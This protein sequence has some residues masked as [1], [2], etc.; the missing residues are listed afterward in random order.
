MIINF[1]VTAFRK[2]IDVK[3]KYVLCQAIVVPEIVAT[4]SQHVVDKKIRRRFHIR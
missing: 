3:Y 1:Q 4:R 2:T